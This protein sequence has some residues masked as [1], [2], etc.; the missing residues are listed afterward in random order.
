M[1]KTVFVLNLIFIQTLELVVLFGSLLHLVVWL[2]VVWF[3][4]M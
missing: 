4:L 3:V 1:V 2:Y